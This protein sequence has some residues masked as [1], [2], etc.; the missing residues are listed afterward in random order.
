MGVKGNS[1]RS[2]AWYP[3][4]L[5]VLASLVL[6]AGT[7]RPEPPHGSAVSGGRANAPEGSGVTAGPTGSLRF[8]IE[9][10]PAARIGDPVPITLRVRNLGKTP[11]E[12][13]LAGRPTAFDITVTR[14]DGSE[15]W[16]RLEGATIS[17]ILGVQVLAPGGMLEFKDTWN[18]RAQSGEQLGPGT[19]TVE[20]ALLTDS[21]PLKTGPASLR[22]SPR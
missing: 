21:T 4:L 22:L 16:R 19:Y 5:F 11:R 17:S 2:R 18:Q 15:V 10:P 9:V 1:D 7:C 8:D 14:A 20:G 12:L 13:Y 6:M 3:E